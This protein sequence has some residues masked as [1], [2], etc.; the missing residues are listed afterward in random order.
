MTIDDKPTGNR[1]A[2]GEMAVGVMNSQVRRTESGLEV[3]RWS[4][5]DDRRVD[6]FVTTRHGGVSSGGYASLNLSLRVGD[7]DTAVLENRMTVAKALDAAPDDFVFCQQTH[8]SGVATVTG[9]HRGRGAFSAA[10]AIAQT[11][12]LVTTVPGVVLAI[13]AADCLPLVLHDP[14]AGVLACVHAGW[15]GT[16][17]GV[18]PAALAEMRRLGADPANVVAAVGPGIHPDDYQVGVDVVDAFRSVFGGQADTL[19]R[20]VDGGKWTVDLGRANVTQLLAAGVREN[21]MHVTGLGTGPGTPFFSHR[22][23]N[24][25]GR[26]AAVARLRGKDLP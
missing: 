6:V 25:C 9:E 19:I 16:A 14:V 24:P 11:D 2:G 12:A 15:R 4:G 3:L 22:A 23:E 5:F 1:P 26:F 21:N 18:T 10:E 20:S 13:L 17:R 8:G 7:D